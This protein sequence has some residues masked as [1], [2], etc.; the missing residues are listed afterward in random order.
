MIIS[1]LCA[2]VFMEFNDS[3]NIIRLLAGIIVLFIGSFTDIR[4][5]KVPNRLWLISGA[6][7]SLLLVA[8]VAHETSAVIP[9]ILTLVVIFY[10]YYFYSDLEFN[11]LPKG[12]DWFF[13]VLGVGSIG[14]YVWAVFHYDIPINI[15]FLL[16]ITFVL[17]VINEVLLL[18][19]E[20]SSR[21]S[22][23]ILLLL[24]FI[25]LGLLSQYDIASIVK[26]VPIAAT[27]TT[28]IDASFMLI[29]SIFLM[30]TAIY[31]MYCSGIIMGGADAKGLMLV[32]LLLPL[33]P[34]VSGLHV[35]TYFYYILEEIPLQAYIFPFSM[36]IL[37]NGAI[38]LL[39]YPVFFFVLNLLKRDFKFPYC[40][41]G[42]R[43]ELEK[44]E[45]KFV[46]L[47][48]IEKDG[49]RKMVLSPPREKAEEKEHLKK[50]TDAGDKKI[51]VQP[52]IP[53]LVA[54][55]VGYLIAI[56]FGNAIHLIIGLFGG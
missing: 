41:F 6:I 53:F 3:L 24:C 45:K 1:I 7:A 20:M 9:V 43:L 19:K 28:G 12:K 40:F 50:L 38:L 25:T 2:S 35:E 22:W 5:R 55:T 14:F 44:F 23:L 21:M 29:T 31:A 37:I 30:I 16:G 33:Y 17:L 56:I 36:T 13:A 51:W 26:G 47:L 15:A 48:E 52:K 8:Y 27:G 4:T 46:W 18:R 32:S 49:K 11:G 54:M 10:Y 39:L 42:Y 34:A